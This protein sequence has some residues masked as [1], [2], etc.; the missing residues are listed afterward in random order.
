MRNFFEQN[1]TINDI[2]CDPKLWIC[3]HRWR[4]ITNMV[5]WRNVA[6]SDWNVANWWDND[7][8][9]IAFSRGNKA[10]VAINNDV[11]PI[12]ATLKTGLPA[13]TYC[14]VISGD[15]TSERSMSFD[16][17]CYY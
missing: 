7:Y 3:E 1:Q 2:V 16:D 13:R 17:V 5:K 12:D 15:L 8:H 10:F 9:S 14:D 11:Q 4:Q 6:T